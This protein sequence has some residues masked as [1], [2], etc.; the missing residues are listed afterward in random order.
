M[1]NILGSESG[2]GLEEN[3]SSKTMNDEIPKALL[4]FSSGSNK[5]SENNFDILIMK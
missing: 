4:T 5:Y 3:K 2:R 1:R